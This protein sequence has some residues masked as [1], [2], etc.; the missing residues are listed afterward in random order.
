MLG[1][2]NLRGSKG[3][4]HNI[5]VGVEKVNDSNDCITNPFAKTIL[6][7]DQMD[8]SPERSLIVS[9]DHRTSCRFWM[10]HRGSSNN[11]M[12]IFFPIH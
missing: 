9:F 4:I 6:M 7:E 1:C 2:K 3:T 12:T 11:C 5:D 8:F 10:L